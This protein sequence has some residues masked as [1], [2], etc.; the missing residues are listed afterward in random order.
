MGAITAQSV[1]NAL[2]PPAVA[3]EFYPADRS[4]L[5]RVI[6]AYL[7]AVQAPPLATV[8]AVIAPHAGYLCSGVVAAHSFK[9]L[10]A[11]AQAT[12]YTVYLLGP[13]HGQPV[14]GVGLANAATFVT[15]L[16][17]VPVA[18]PDVDRLLALG[19]PYHLANSA[20][21]LE[22]CLEVELPFLQTVLSTF[23]I[24]PL[25]VDESA[26]PAR[27]GADLASLV[28][29]DS[30]M[31]IVVS[32]D[33]SHYAPYAQARTQDQRFLQAVVANDRQRVAT[34]QACGLIPILVLMEVVARLGWQAHL[35]A[36]SNSGDT[37]GSKAAVVGYGAVAYTDPPQPW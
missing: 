13:A 35:L 9:A 8:R 36:Y 3:G 27:V 33:L 15:P 25:L 21:A 4:Q 17:C 28:A 22:H 18:Q 34:G 12:P 5:R 19:E 37:C 31:L 14:N 29:A 26:D 23:S 16:G 32:S 30:R 7:R 1:T 11:L 2:R 6:A 24:V 10:A 20:H